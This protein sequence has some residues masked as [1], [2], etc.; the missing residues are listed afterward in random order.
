MIELSA[1]IPSNSA[2]AF[3]NVNRSCNT[4]TINDSLTLREVN[5]GRFNLLSH[6]NHHEIITSSPA[7]LNSA[8]DVNFNGFCIRFLNLF[9]YIARKTKGVLSQYNSPLFF[10]PP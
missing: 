6:R 2:V 1:V 8:S 7:F 4:R 5:H 9:R 3:L 10:P